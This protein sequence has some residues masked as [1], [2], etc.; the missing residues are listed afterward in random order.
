VVTK[1]HVIL[2]KINISFRSVFVKRMTTLVMATYNKHRLLKHLKC[3]FKVNLS[4][5][6]I[7]K[8]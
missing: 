6:F 5:K 7:V 1:Q 8:M 4:T 3:M 2:F